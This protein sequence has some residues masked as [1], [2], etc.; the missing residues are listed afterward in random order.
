MRCNALCLFFCCA[1][2][3][4]AF[5]Q[6][7][8]VQS[9]R[10]D[11]VI[12]KRYYQPPSAAGN[13][14]DSVA[15][16]LKYRQRYLQDSLASVFI[17]RPNPERRNL[18]LDSMFKEK[19]YKGYDFLEPQGN[20]KS[21]MREGRAR[22]TRDQW[23]ILIIVAL[24]VYMAV[25]NRAMSRDVKNVLQS[26]YNNHILSQVSKEE[27]LL[28]SWAFIGLFILFGFTFGLFL[29]Q[30]T[31]YYEVFYSISGIQLF[32]SFALLVIVLFAVKLIVLRFLGFVFNV[33]RLVGEYISVLYLTYFNITF[34]FLPLSLCFSL[35]ATQYIPYV[36]AVA[37]V[38]VVVIFVWQYLRSSVNIISNFRFHKFYLFTYLCALEICPILILIK[39]LNN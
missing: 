36:L 6:T 13:L 38:L 9:T 34:V 28:N 30:L 14:L 12:K 25:L 5:A 23:V 15:N 10:P 2:C 22:R 19:V 27:N 17:K 16:A 37:L 24:L 39:A 31:T 20:H 33:N 7:E 32:S 8:T 18:F 35:L 21:M 11:S 26:F 1:L 29:Y 4:S 3:L